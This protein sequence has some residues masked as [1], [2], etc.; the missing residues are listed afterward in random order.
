MLNLTNFCNYHWEELCKKVVV[1]VQ[2]PQKRLDKAAKVR[3]TVFMLLIK[4]IE[5]LGVFCGIL[6]SFLV[7]RSFLDIGFC[8]F[9][10]S[11][12]CLCFSAIKQ[13]NWNLTL[14]QSAFLFSNVLGVSNY[15]FGV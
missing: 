7:A 8:L 9:L 13:K 14:L 6:G 5:F 10:V 1:F 2:Q 4:V 12:V 3:Y 15:V 11:S